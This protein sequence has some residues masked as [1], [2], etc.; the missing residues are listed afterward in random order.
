MADEDTNQAPQSPPAP[1]R[2]ATGTSVSQ[3]S[4][5]GFTNLKKLN[6]NSSISTNNSTGSV[7]TNTTTNTANTTGNSTSSAI[8][9]NALT[10][11]FTRNRSNTT[12]DD[13]QFSEDEPERLS[14]TLERRSSN[15]FRL[16]KKSKRKGKN[17]KDLTVQTDGNML[18]EPPNVLTRK[19]SVNS[20]VTNTLHN[21]FHRSSSNNNNNV[22]LGANNLNNIAANNNIDILDEQVVRNAVTLSSNNSNSTITDAN[23]AQVFKFTDPNYSLEEE[24]D[25]M[26][27][28]K[29]LFVPADQFLKLKLP[30]SPVSSDEDYN[31][32]F[33]F[34]N[35]LLV[36]FKPIILSSQQK[37]LSNGL[38]GCQ[39]IMTEEDISNY[40][41]DNYSSQLTFEGE[42][43]SNDIKAR[44]INQDLNSFFTRLLTLFSKDFKSNIK[45]ELDPLCKEW[46][47]LNG[48]WLYF[49]NRIF[50]FIL[51]CFTSLNENPFI[52]ESNIQIE[53]LLLNTFKEVIILPFINLRYRLNT[54]D[55]N[56][57]RN[58][59][60]GSLKD[61]MI[62]CFGMIN[63]MQI[64]DD[65][66][67]SNNDFIEI[68]TWLTQL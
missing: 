41:R 14:P 54:R 48:Q 19:S 15:V 9:P 44:E 37:R 49:R 8:K 27:M 56:F 36:L 42:E 32:D 1:T 40:I 4:S 38:K 21:L 64:Y 16:G 52:L 34:W 20:P 53:Q 24:F 12:L 63:S 68:F 22:G 39:L 11:L 58:Y 33:K 50:F 7:T 57:L 5:V 46:V 6:T 65:N 47:K 67:D 18:R 59:N 45:E 17:P 23:F 25:D 60:E 51:N 10:R 2:M 31:D 62:H 3:I 55:N 29:K 66:D 28:Y 13:P 43:E 30:N 35:T 26:E 61:N